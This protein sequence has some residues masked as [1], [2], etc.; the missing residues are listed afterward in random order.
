M[1]CQLQSPEKVLF[2]GEAEIVVARS[3]QGEFAVMDKHAPLLAALDASPLR[4]KA[5]GHEYT[6][7]LSGGVIQVTK[8]GVTILAREAIPASE[9]DLA[10]VT[11]RRRELENTKDLQTDEMNA[12]DSP[13]QE[14][15]AFLIVQ[16]KIGDGLG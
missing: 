1:H 16:E 9:I 2:N 4:I 13:T 10:A 6:F 15:I 8:S 7:A 3:F 5:Q 12:K 11:A 14:E